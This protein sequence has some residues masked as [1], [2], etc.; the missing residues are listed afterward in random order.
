MI[1]RGS[2]PEGVTGLG[3]SSIG[4]TVLCLTTIMSRAFF[5]E[6]QS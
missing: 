6:A 2:E 4:I 3:L 1:R 5:R